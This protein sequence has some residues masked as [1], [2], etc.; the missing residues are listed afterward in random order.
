MAKY[1]IL[2]GIYD[3]KLGPTCINPSINCEWLRSWGNSRNLIQDGLNTKSNILSIFLNNVLVQVMK[4]KIYDQRLRGNTMRCALFCFV[5]YNMYLIPKQ[6]LK[7]IIEGYKD[8]ARK[9]DNNLKTAELDEYILN[10]EKELNRELLASIGQGV[11]EHKRIDIL[12]A[13]QGYTQ[14]LSQESLGKLSQ[15][16][17]K[18]V[19]NIDKSTQQLL[20]LEKM[21]IKPIQSY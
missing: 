20:K 5:H 4:F 8:K 16:Q 15:N 7:R 17:K 21:D 3:H 14:L 11:I 6:I 12:S 18:A 1:R 19:K 10:R 2:I 13:I 9:N